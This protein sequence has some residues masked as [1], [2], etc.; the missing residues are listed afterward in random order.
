MLYLYSGILL[1]DKK[2]ITNTCNNVDGPHKHFCSTKGASH[3]REHTEWFHL[4]EVLEQTKPSI[5]TESR[6]ELA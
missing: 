4:H 1:S 2:R 3:K 5:V 6:S